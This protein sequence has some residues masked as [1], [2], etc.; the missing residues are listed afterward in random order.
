MSPDGEF[1]GACQRGGVVLLDAKTGEAV[2]LIA[3]KR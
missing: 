1:V 3:V 2:R